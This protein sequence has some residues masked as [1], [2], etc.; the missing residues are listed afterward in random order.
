M[1]HKIWGPEKAFTYLGM[2]GNKSF[3]G[4]NRSKIRRRRLVGLIFKEKK[5]KEGYKTYTVRRSKPYYTWDASLM[6]E[7]SKYYWR[8][9]EEYIQEIRQSKQ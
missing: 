2:F 3:S 6:P 1:K 5:P 9:I 8:E 7:D 4:D